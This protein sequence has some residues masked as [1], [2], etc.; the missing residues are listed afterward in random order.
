MHATEHTRTTTRLHLK[1]HNVV[2]RPC[3]SL[4]TR[5]RRQTNRLLQKKTRRHYSST[6]TMSQR[7][8]KQA[9]Q[10]KNT[11]AYRIFFAQQREVH[12]ASRKQLFILPHT[13]TDR[14]T[15]KKSPNYFVSS[16]KLKPQSCPG[17]PSMTN[18]RIPKTN[19][20]RCKENSKAS[21]P[22]PPVPPSVPV[23]ANHGPSAY[24][25]PLLPYH[26]MSGPHW[27]HPRQTG[28]NVP[29]RRL[30]VACSNA[31]PL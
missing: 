24:N 28:V 2:R 12:T 19:K 29:R 14:K 25:P 21:S 9:T 6:S 3:Q 17:L 5:S 30:C 8:L 13:G 11:P 23:D 27:E 7:Y 18:V 4:S 1:T 26:R 22:P 15:P 31:V 20:R 16:R 10:K